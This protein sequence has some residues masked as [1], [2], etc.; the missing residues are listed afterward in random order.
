MGTSKK[1]LFFAAMFFHYPRGHLSEPEPH[2][3][4]FASRWQL[5]LIQ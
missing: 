5:S 2:L 1:Q 3:Q 4:I